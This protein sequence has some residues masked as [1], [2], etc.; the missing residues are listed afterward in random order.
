LENKCASRIVRPLSRNSQKSPYT[1]SFML[2]FQR[3]NYYTH[4]DV[5]RLTSRR[6]LT[7]HLPVFYLRMVGQ[8]LKFTE[9]PKWRAYMRPCENKVLRRILG[10]KKD[11]VTAGWRKRRKKELNN[12]HC[13]RIT[14]RVVNWS[15]VKRA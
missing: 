1:A 9:H 14:A 10:S 15:R 4:E 3:R 5:M 8:I 7:I 13:S 11:E 6:L 2:T 12:L